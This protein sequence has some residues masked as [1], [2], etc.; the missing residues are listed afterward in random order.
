MYLPYTVVMI[1]YSYFVLQQAFW[2][3][4]LSLNQAQRNCIG[5]IPTPYDEPLFY[6]IGLK[7]VLE[8]K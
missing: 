2:V 6:R 7:N 3:A 1:C 5:T 4:A 8:S